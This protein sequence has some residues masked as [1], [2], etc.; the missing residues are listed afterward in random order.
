VDSNYEP[1]DITVLRDRNGVYLPTMV[2][3]D[4]SRLTDVEG[5]II[6]LHADG[7]KIRGIQHHLAA[8]MR[9][10]ISYVTLCTIADAVSSEVILWQNRQLEEFYSIIFLVTLRI[11]VRDGGLVVNKSAYF[12][13]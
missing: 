8:V 4:S 12:A 1:V 7:M 3:K 2:P 10:D 11:E 9:V 5:M 6:S 13:I